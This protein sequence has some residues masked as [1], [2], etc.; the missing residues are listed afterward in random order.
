[1][2]PG[3]EQ[4]CPH[5]GSYGM[6]CVTPTC[7]KAPKLAWCHNMSSLLLVYPLDAII[8]YLPILVQPTCMGKVWYER[9]M[10]QVISWKLPE[11][12]EAGVD[13]KGKQK[14]SLQCIALRPGAGEHFMGWSIGDPMDAEALLSCLHIMLLLQKAVR[15]L[16]N[17]ESRWSLSEPVGIG[18]RSS[19][20]LSKE[21]SEVAPQVAY[22]DGDEALQWLKPCLPDLCQGHATTRKKHDS[23][24]WNVQLLSTRQGRRACT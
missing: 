14:L 19:S 11:T 12:D 6:C 10:K 18:S 8:P 22:L 5:Q 2:I 15:S 17:T 20:Y 4:C 23:H 21:R 1:M 9:V 16:S 3:L 24:H 7:T 13:V